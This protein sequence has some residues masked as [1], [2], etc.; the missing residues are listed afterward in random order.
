MSAG[1]P[2]QAPGHEQREQQR[3]SSATHNAVLA[4][5]P[6]PSSASWYGKQLSA[7]ALQ[8]CA[9]GRI[10]VRAENAFLPNE[11]D[12]GADPATF[13]NLEG[14]IKAFL[15]LGMDGF[16]TDHPHVGRLA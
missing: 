12:A 11:F 6:Q 13:G 16:F 3:M 10:S 8:A 2:A 5:H 1:G 4:R 14:Q 7:V 9:D 15:K